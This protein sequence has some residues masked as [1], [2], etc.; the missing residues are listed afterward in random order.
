MT[1]T[2]LEGQ[3]QWEHKLVLSNARGNEASRPNA[4]LYEIERIAN[5]LG[6]YGW[7]MVSAPNLSERLVYAWFVRQVI[8]GAEDWPS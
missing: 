3:Q 1:V 5:E 4:D 7:K 6:L 2:V 8:E